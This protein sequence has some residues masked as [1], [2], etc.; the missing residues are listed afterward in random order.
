MDSGT[1]QFR[2]ITHEKHRFLIAVIADEDTTVGFLLAGIGEYFGIGKKNLNYMIVTE[3]TNLGAVE[4]YFHSIYNQPNIGV[5]LIATDIWKDLLP[6][7][8]NMKKKMLP[9]ILEI[10]TKNKIPLKMKRK[11]N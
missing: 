3:D 2:F 5:I 9:I 1:T 10:P 7:F 4:K 11:S 8:D 6:T